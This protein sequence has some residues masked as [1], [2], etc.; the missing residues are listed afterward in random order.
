MKRIIVLILCGTI[1]FSLIGCSNNEQ[2]HGD[3]DYTPSNPSVSSSQNYSSSRLSE[4]N[5]NL[6]SQ[7]TKDIVDK[8]PLSYASAWATASFGDSTI[9]AELDKN[10]FQCIAKS[11]YDSS[12]SGIRNMLEDVKLASIVMNKMPDTLTYQNI[13]VKMLDK[14]GEETLE[15]GL[16]KN[17]GSFSLNEISGNFKKL[18]DLTTGIN[19]FTQNQ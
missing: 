18:G 8:L 13:Y 14:N 11:K 16:A 9:C 10:N 2:L 12:S 3:F 1:L 5:S 15:I 6:T 7:Q 17:N 4:A 19:E